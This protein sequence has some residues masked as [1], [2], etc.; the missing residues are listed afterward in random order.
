MAGGVDLRGRNLPFVAAST[1]EEER[2]HNQKDDCGQ[3]LH[4]SPAAKTTD[5]L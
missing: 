1:P 4:R 3:K 5:I 2:R